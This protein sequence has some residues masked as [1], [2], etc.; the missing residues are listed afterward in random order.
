[1]QG[2]GRSRS[3]S[4]PARRP[5]AAQGAIVRSSASRTRASIFD[6]SGREL[7]QSL[8]LLGRDF[9]IDELPQTGEQRYLRLDVPGFPPLEALL[10]GISWEFGSGEASP[11]TIAIA[12]SREP[13]DARQHAFRR[14]LIGWFAGL[15]LT[16]LIVLGGLL[17]FVLLPLRKLERQVREVEAGERVSLEGG[18]RLR[19]HPACRQLER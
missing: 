8:S 3:P 16:M 2:L 15:T 6:G 5:H 13:Y 17:T 10:M 7:W 11:F 12:V 19:A 9:P 14:N 18:I 1:L 4:Q